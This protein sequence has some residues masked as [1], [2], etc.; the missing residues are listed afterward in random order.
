LHGAPEVEDAFQ[1]TFLV[2]IRKAGTIR[3][4]DAVGGWLHRVAHRVAAQAGRDRSRTGR[5]EQRG[6]GVPDVIAAREAPDVGDWLV[7]LH[8][9]LAR[10]PDR[11]RQPIALCYLEG[12]THAQAAFELQWSEATLRRRLADARDRLRVRLTR[13]GVTVTASALAVAMATPAP[14][15]VPPGWVDDLARI[16]AGPGAGS[17]APAAAAR[18]AGKV[19]RRLV[20]ARALTVANVATV[21]LTFGLAAGHVVPAGRVKADDPGRSTMPATS[22]APVRAPGSQ[23]PVG[24]PEPKQKSPSGVASS[25][26]TVDLLRA[27]NYPCRSRT[28]T[29][30]PLWRKDGAGPTDDSTSA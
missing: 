25:I 15:A 23:Q 16:A 4:R 12:K 24:K 11:L 19:G 9:E 8:E 26:P 5:R 17:A 3:G 18:L 20:A 2:L 10:L 1:A 30:T 22:S 7:P 27:R 21:L 14:A 6:G 13:R 29:G 28:A